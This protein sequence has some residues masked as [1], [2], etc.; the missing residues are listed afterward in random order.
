MS[1]PLATMRAAQALREKGEPVAPHSGNSIETEG[2][3]QRLVCGGTHSASYER[4]RILAAAAASHHRGPRP[5][6]A[7]SS[8]LTD[9][10]EH[11]RDEPR[12]AP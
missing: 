2:D 9:S 1:Q 12:S 3:R 7:N 5:H 10:D 4:E 8:Q 6:D 11:G